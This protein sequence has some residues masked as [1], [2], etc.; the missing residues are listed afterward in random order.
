[1]FFMRIFTVVF[2]I[3]DYNEERDIAPGKDQTPLQRAP[4]VAVAENRVQF[5]LLGKAMGT[6]HWPLIPS[7]LDHA[8]L[9]EQ[10]SVR[11]AGCDPEKPPRIH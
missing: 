6:V 4:R 11:E 7:D 1:M 9:G 8:P 10:C 2:S 5:G 3:V